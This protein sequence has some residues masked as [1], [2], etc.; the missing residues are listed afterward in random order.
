[1]T[2]GTIRIR[3]VYDDLDPDDG[4]RA[5]VDR[6][7]PRGLRKE[8]AHFD[9]WVRAVAPSTELRHWFGHD[10]DRFAEFRTRY[11]EEL[12]TPERQAALAQLR[13]AATPGPLTLLTATRDVSHSHVA[14]LA[15]VLRRDS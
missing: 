7:W 8:S 14:V 15:E 6:V 2:A 1:M 10:P 4:F 11:H 13:T 5:L 9:A 12:T 3:R